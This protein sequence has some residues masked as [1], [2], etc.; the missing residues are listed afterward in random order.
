MSSGYFSE[1]AVFN[2]IIITIVDK[3]PVLTNVHTSECKKR[4]GILLSKY[5]YYGLPLLFYAN[6]VNQRKE[7]KERKKVKITDLRVNKQV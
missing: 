3:S 2:I 1:G 5:Y 7:I 6:Y 4:R